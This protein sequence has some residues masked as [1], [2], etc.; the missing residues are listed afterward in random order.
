MAT[1]PNR[2]ATTKFTRS[3]KVGKR[4]I[5]RDAQGESIATN[6][7]FIRPDG[8]YRLV[9][10][11]SRLGTAEIERLM[12]A[13]HNK[14]KGERIG[15]KGRGCSIE[16]GNPNHPNT[17]L[18]FRFP[19]RELADAL[20]VLNSKP[21]SSTK[22]RKAGVEN[23]AKARAVQAEKRAAREREIQSRLQRT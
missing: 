16:L 22:S 14:F 15:V 17:S 21:R 19:A 11:V 18:V 9:A 10:E 6:S 1:Q 20:K 23:L 2:Q 3:H 5:L 13:L 4:E 8:P 12:L 7:G